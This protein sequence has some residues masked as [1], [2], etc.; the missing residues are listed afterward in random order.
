MQDEQRS[1]EPE[2]AP[3][4]NALEKQLRRMTL[5]TPRIERDRL[6]YAAGQAAGASSSE[7]FGRDGWVTYDNTGRPRYIAGPS[8]AGRR[9]WQVTTY[10]MSAAALFLATMLLW[11]GHRTP[12]AQQQ[13]PARPVDAIPTLRD[14]DL[15]SPP[16]FATRNNWPSIPSIDSGYLGVRYV[17]LTRGVGALSPDSRSDDGNEETPAIRGTEPSTPRAILNELLPATRRLNS[18]RS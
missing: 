9:F 16:R 3:E 14:S 10:T 6:M 2:I 12:L 15:D 11:Q 13:S 8:S 1:R 17:A 4:L 7:A 18:S 5:A